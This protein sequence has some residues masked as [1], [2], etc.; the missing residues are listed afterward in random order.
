M[1]T[2][3]IDQAI[4]IMNLTLEDI[5][6]REL[7]MTYTYH[8]YSLFNTLWSA[9]KTTTGDKLDW[10]VAL[11]DEGNAG[12]RGIWAEETYNKLNLT[13]KPTVNWVHASSN[14]SYNAIELAMN[15]GEAQ[16]YDDMQLLYRNTYREFADEVF[17]AL[18][19]T[20][21][22]STDKDH[23]HGLP[24]WL[25]IGTNG[26]TGGWTGY[27]AHYDDGGSPGTTYPPGGVTS[28]ATS[29]A[30]WASYYADHDGDL[31]DSLFL[32]LFE[33][34]QKLNFVG[35]KQPGTHDVK[36]SIN[37]S[38]YT[39]NNVIKNIAALYAKADDQMGARPNIHYQ[40]AP[41]FR[42]MDFQYVPIFDTANTATYGTDPIFGVN[43]QL[44]YPCVLRGWD[45]NVGKPRQRDSQS[46]VL[47]VDL[48]TEY[49]MKCT[50]RRMA[51][52]LINEQ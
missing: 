30:R 52:F 43:H 40:L 38:L 5:Q 37:F 4:D 14:F 46:L 12:H 33:A 7:T 24:T 41:Q 45:F 28:T 27:D 22:S 50:D 21:S 11:K 48:H 20:P 34:C 39:S 26:S 18:V 49:Q 19:A 13:E 2:I 3:T 6:R 15:K 36:S 16:I 31:D 51:G 8:N 17:E 32:M 29:L 35:P 10:L 1:E 9:R 25:S 42:N 47:T 44:L 23:P